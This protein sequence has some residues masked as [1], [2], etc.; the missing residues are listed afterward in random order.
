MKKLLIVLFS[1][2]PVV[3]FAAG[4]GDNEYV[5]DAPINE[6]DMVSRQNGAKL[7][8]NYCM[9]CHSLEYL[10]YKRM[11]EDLRMPPELVQ[12]NLNFAGDK[13]GDQMVTAMD[14]DE[15]KKWFGATPPDLTMVNRRRS[16]DWIYSYLTNFYKDESRPYGY[17]NH[18]FE[19]VGMPHVMAKVE[20]RL[21]EE[22]F[23]EAMAD[24]T[25]FL[26]YAGAPEKAVRERIGVYVLV[27][28]FILLIPAYL[29]YK[30]YWKDVH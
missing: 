24:I 10:R 14:P 23:K 29:L 20:E 22:K 11:A 15:A 25:N 6:Q 26:V 7:F 27:F 18:V 8:V 19:N 16:A 2:L 9:G 5:V 28:L 4:G 30:E 21:G 1:L 13:I 3:S 12:E 17:N